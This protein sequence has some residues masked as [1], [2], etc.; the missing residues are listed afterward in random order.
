[1]FSI[2]DDLKA[3]VESGVAAVVAT[4]SAE[5]RPH[6]TL[7]WGP[8][9]HDDRSTVTVFIEPSRGGLVLEDAASTGLIAL[10]VGHPTTY[11]SIQLKGR[12]TAVS[13]AAPEDHPWVERHRG[14][15]LSATSLV[16]DDPEIVRGYWAGDHDLKRVDIEVTRAFDQT[17]GPEA[18]GPL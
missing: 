18:G 12:A 15:F 11:R 5:G 2:D 16:G 1:V 8:R 3:F 9:V 10:T 14:D 6:L 4:A 7:V 13:D 17:P